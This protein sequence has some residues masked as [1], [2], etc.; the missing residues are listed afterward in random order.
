M[1][2]WDN[3]LD[4]VILVGVFGMGAG[5]RTG[6]GG[7]S[8]QSAASAAQEQDF[9]LLG[10]EFFFRPC[11]NEKPGC[12]VIEGRR[13]K[14]GQFALKGPQKLADMQKTAIQMPEKGT[15]KWQL[16]NYWSDE[17]RQTRADHSAYIALNFAGA[18][19]VCRT[20]VQTLMHHHRQ[21]ATD[22]VG[23]Q[24]HHR[25]LERLQNTLSG[26]AVAY[27]NSFHSH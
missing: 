17:F 23:G 4:R 21:L 2:H 5:V 15:Y 25:A 26:A 6:H 3:F 18:L 22:A 1:D 7:L 10:P 24:R 16:F 27:E 13:P 9:S 14:S 11:V 8:N 20:K 12:R 19:D